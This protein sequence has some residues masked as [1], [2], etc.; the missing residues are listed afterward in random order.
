MIK[1]VTVPDDVAIRT[2]RMLEARVSCGRIDKAYE[3]KLRHAGESL[4][5]SV[6]HKLSQTTC[7]RRGS[8]TRSLKNSNTVLVQFRYS[9]CQWVLAVNLSDVKGRLFDAS[10]LYLLEGD[11]R[12]TSKAHSSSALR[13]PRSRHASRD[14]YF[15]T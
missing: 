15:R 4:H 6:C 3:P 10:I 1:S 11:A 14:K 7:E 9:L 12:E 5:Q 8:R 13:P 2:E